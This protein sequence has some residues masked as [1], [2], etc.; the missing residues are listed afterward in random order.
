MLLYYVVYYFA[1]SS[2]YLSIRVVYEEISSRPDMKHNVIIKGQFSW[3]SIN[4]YENF[5]SRLSLE[6]PR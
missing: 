5:C 2:F 1:R 6:Q 3:A 4:F